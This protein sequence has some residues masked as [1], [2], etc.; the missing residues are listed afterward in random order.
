MMQDLRLMLLLFGVITIIVLFLH[1]VWARRKERSALFYDQKTKDQNQ[2]EDDVLLQ[3]LD[4]EGVGEVKI[5]KKAT[6]NVEKNAFDKAHHKKIP[7]QTKYQA[8]KFDSSVA[9]VTASSFAQISE[10]ETQLQKK[11]DDLSHQSKETHHPSI[12]KEQKVLVLHVAA[13]SSRNFSGETLLKS[14]LNSHF[15]FGDMNIFHRYLTLTGERIT[16]FS[17]ANM[18]KPGFFDL[19]KMAHFS[20]P[21]IS[22]FMTLPCYGHASENFKLMLQS[23]QKIA[24]ELGGLVLDDQRQMITPQKL[25]DYNALIRSTPHL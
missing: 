11:S 21:G 2:K 14:I 17:L 4:E 15:Q 5:L 7:S 22:I 20:T 1:G 10:T 9:C 24:D 23:A 6:P 8:L 3:I 12:Q 19:K 16:L 25:E 18:V 13:H